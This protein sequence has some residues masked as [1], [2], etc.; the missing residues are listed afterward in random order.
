MTE[1]NSF[2]TPWKLVPIKDGEYLE[3]RTQSWAEPDRDYLVETMRRLYFDPALGAAVG[4]I[5]RADI[6]RELS[7]EAIGELIRKNLRG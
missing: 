7:R 3:G 6:A 1:S 5:A 2:L 4:Q